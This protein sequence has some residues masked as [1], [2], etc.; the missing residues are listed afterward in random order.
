M[1][2]KLPINTNILRW[3]RVSAGL[4]IDDV[5]KKINK[6]N[7]IIL[8]WESG[9]LSPS[10]SQ[11]ENLSY[12]IYKR[13]IAL[14]FFPD[15][16]EEE[17]PKTEFRT[18]PDSFNETL[19]YELIKLYRKAKIFQLN[20]NSLN[21]G[22]KVINP[23]LLDTFVLNN[24]NN[25]IS[26]TKNIRDYIE[27]SIDQQF[28]WQSMDIALK[29]WRQAL[30][31]KGVFIFKDAFH[32]DEYSGFCIYDNNYPLIYINNSMPLSRQIF[33]I[34]HELGHL[35]FHSG[36]VFFRDQSI[37]NSFDDKYL[38]YEIKCNQFANE[39]LVPSN[40]FE[41]ENL[42]VSE[43][44]FENLSRRYNVSRE[45][46]LRNFLNRKIINEK[47]YNQMSEKW[48]DEA[49]NSKVKSKS[50]HYYNTQRAYLGDYYIQL[51]FRKY[52][53]KKISIENLSD[54]LNVK[55]K[56]IS[57]FEHYAF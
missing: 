36:G 41:K 50:G 9:D 49:I 17:S 26:F 31:N 18:L 6:E 30:E 56:N 3:A 12:H 14:F 39:L 13:P 32:N 42:T 7:D 5:S 45:V 40:Y 16:P 24:S 8:S 54:F 47:Y 15:I 20:L 21:E 23:N 53:Q 38:Q 22:S 28:S 37:P 29:N 11:L 2:E 43:N 34:F 10:Y 55:I 46:I 51:A 35:L 25:I 1:K 27:I 52:Y 57:T 19:P 44:N 4:S 33:T 48:I